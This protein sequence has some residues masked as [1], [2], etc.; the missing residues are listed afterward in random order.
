MDFSRRS[1]WTSMETMWL[2]EGVRGSM[3][4]SNSDPSR[5][6]I[7]GWTGEGRKEREGCIAGIAGLFHG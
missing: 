6:Q 1:K 3:S 5:F 4:S 7:G 2:V